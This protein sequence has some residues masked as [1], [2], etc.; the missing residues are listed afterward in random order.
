MKLILTMPNYEIMESTTK[1]LRELFV[2]IVI[3]EKIKEG[4]RKWPKK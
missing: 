2:P 4:V 3:A 1:E